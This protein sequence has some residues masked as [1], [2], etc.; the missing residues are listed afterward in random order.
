MP[1][2]PSLASL[3]AITRS[4]ILLRASRGDSGPEP[5]GMVAR[6]AGCQAF[7]SVPSLEIASTGASIVPART[8][9]VPLP[10]ST[11]SRVI[12]N[13][14]RGTIRTSASRMSRD[15]TSIS[16]RIDSILERFRENSEAPSQ[17]SEMKTRIISSAL[18]AGSAGTDRPFDSRKVA[19][20]PAATTAPLAGP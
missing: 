11:S 8:I 15:S 19:D 12:S 5:R 14:A 20:T 4:E 6:Q 17:S 1:M 18:A 13:P 16:S 10:N 9:L 3:R 2:Q 7:L